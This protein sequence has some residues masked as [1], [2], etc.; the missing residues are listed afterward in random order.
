MSDDVAA[1]YDVVA[2]RYASLFLDDLENDADAKG[3][4]ARFVDLVEPVM[5]PV[6]DVGCG[7]G[8]GVDALVRAGLP[9]F[10][11]DA[12]PGMIEQ[13]QRAFPQLAF[14]VDDL[15]ALDAA[16]S[17]FSGI[18]ARYSI[19]HLAPDALPAV[20]AEWERVLASGAPVVLFF[21]ASREPAAHGT[22]FDHQVATAYE[23]DPATIGELLSAAGFVGVQHG[24]APAP[25]GGRPLDKGVVLARR[26]KA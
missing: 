5:G 16:S 3:W 18:F 13:A 23:F 9:A 2:E 11:I 10:G 24:A 19:I 6:V 26:P 8:H 1:A 22:P 7:P 14:F 21:F 15:T 25:D 4:L 12:S 17:S 20:F